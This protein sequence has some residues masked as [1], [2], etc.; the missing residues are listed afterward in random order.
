MNDSKHG[1]SR[2]DFLKTT[3]YVTPV[4]LTMKAVPALAGSG[5]RRCH[6]KGN[7]GI[8]QE[9]HGYTDGPPPGLAGKPN[10]DFNDDVDYGPYGDSGA[11]RGR[12]PW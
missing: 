3:A 11:H 8:G 10:Q 9:K 7:N 4:I 5:S 1:K 6:V 12:R 2:R